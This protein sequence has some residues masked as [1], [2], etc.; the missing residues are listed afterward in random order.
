[1]QNH[2]P[3]FHFI[4]ELIPSP[5]ISDKEAEEHLRGI[6]D[7][8]ALGSKPKISPALFSHRIL[9][10]A[11]GKTY[12]WL[13]EFSGADI[14][15]DD[16]AEPESNLAGAIDAEVRA[17]LAPLGDIAF[18]SAYEDISPLPPPTFAESPLEGLVSFSDGENLRW[19]DFAADAK[20]E[21]K[22]QILPDEL[23]AAIA[24]C[25]AQIPTEPDLK[26]WGKGHI[27]FGTQDKPHIAY[28]RNYLSEKSEAASP[29]DR[30]KILAFM[31]FQSREGSTAA[32]NSY[33]NQIVTWGT[34]WGGLGAMGKVVEYAVSVPAVRDVF[35]R[36]GVRY[37]AQN[38]YDV[39]DLESKKVITGKKEALEIM[40]HSLPLLY[41]LIH[42]SRDLATRNAVTDAQLR[43]FM[44]GSANISRSEE[45]ATQA[46]FN[47]IAH[48]KHWAPGYVTGALEWAVP[49][50]G[51]GPPSPE[52]DRR[53][54]VLVGRYFYGK[55]RAFKWIPDWKQFKM[56]WDH[57]KK[58]GLDCLSDPF[59]TASAPPED[60]PFATHPA[61]PSTAQAPSTATAAPIEALGDPLLK[62][63]PELDAVLAGG[64]AI[65][66]GSKGKGVQAIQLALIA[67][68]YEVRGG[69][70]GSF[71][72][73]MEQAVKAFQEKQK[74]GADGIVG[75]G[76][77]R[78]LDA[79][80]KI[81]Q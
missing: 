72:G 40:R 1:M 13:I 63:Q 17:R 56:Y 14:P 23:I 5:H 10:R 65:R 44:N 53:L 60:D 20:T 39:V 11:D 45:I 76:T 62:G 58:D 64:G 50:A 16:E 73:G 33:D 28:V 8:F 35:T 25:R 34:G 61:T 9:K 81:R 36:A 30:R 32:I 47:L 12:A 37:R 49:Q 46:L 74:L 26:P 22:G 77:L 24:Q 2:F 55:A 31:A 43:T 57:M 3:V 4:Y 18:A 71:G 19:E 54:A 69:A 15:E 7:S 66:K 48:L 52:R 67:L 38:I 41:M 78:A 27:Y 79:A 70:D 59:I 68:G 75:R 21:Q 29:G 6:T 80:L 42:A 51:E